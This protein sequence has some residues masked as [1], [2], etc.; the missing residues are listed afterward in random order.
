MRANRGVTL[1]ELLIAGSVSSVVLTAV[2][3]IF[4]SLYSQW[5]FQVSR[6]K[7]IQEANL[8]IDLLAAQI[9]PAIYCLSASGSHTNVFQYPANTD[10]NGNYVPA[11][12]GI[13]F[14]YIPGSRCDFYLSNSSGIS[15]KRGTLLWREYTLNSY[16]NSGWTADSAWSLLP[17]STT[18]GRMGDIVALSFSTSGKPANVVNVSV[19]VQVTEKSTTS[20]YTASRDVYMENHN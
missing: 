3:L 10:A 6:A 5:A 2:L 8:A 7:A 4:T 19:T 13:W 9:R 18:M 17:G 1:V 16:G 11:W 12:N 20:T 14:D 15:S